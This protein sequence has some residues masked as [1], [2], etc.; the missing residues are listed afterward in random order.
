[1]INIPLQPQRRPPAMAPVLLG[2]GK[3]SDPV[4]VAIPLNDPR[5]K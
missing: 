4:I 3:C 1:M 2:A 5:K